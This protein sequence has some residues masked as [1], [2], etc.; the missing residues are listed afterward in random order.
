MEAMI[1]IRVDKRETA[2]MGQGLDPG[3]EKCHFGF[4][5]VIKYCDI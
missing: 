5:I 4:I 2:G 3:K 1:P